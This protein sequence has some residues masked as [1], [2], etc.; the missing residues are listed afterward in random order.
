MSSVGLVQTW[1][2]DH[3]HF[4]AGRITAPPSNSVILSD[5]SGLNILIGFRAFSNSPCSIEVP[6]PPNDRV[7]WPRE[8]Q[9]AQLGLLK[10][11]VAALFSVFWE[12]WSSSRRETAWR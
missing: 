3:N 4:I 9:K 11:G 8:H 1:T 12:V 10:R 2:I 5:W 6:V 7:V